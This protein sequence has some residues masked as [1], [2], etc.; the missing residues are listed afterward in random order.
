VKNRCIYFNQEGYNQG[1]ANPPKAGRL[2]IFLGYAPTVGKTYAMLD[3]ALRMR[4]DGMPVVVACL[5]PQGDG[6]YQDQLKALGYEDPGSVPKNLDLDVLLSH[7]K[8]LV[9]VDELAAKNPP[10]SRHPYRYQDVEELLAAGRDVYTTLNIQELESLRDVILE[11]DNRMVHETVPDRIFRAASVIELIDLPPEEILQRLERKMASGEIDA[12]EAAPYLSIE[13]LT[14]LRQIALRRTAGT[15]EE[16]YRGKEKEKPDGGVLVC[17]SSHPLSERL[18]RVGKRRADEQHVPWHVLYIETPERARPLVAYRE[19]LERSLTLAEQLGARVHRQ[20]SLDLSR[21]V[22]A[23]V[24]QN[25]IHSVVVGAPRHSGRVVFGKTQVERLVSM[26]DSAEILIVKEDRKLSSMDQPL[27]SGKREPWLDYAKA[28]GI[29]ALVTGISYPL[30]L[31]I[32]PVN[33]VMLYLVAVMACAFY[34]GRGPAI[35]AS[36]TSVLAFDYFMV[37]PR[38]SLTIADTQYLL[39]FLGLFIAGLVISSLV[40]KI[41]GQVDASHQREELISALYNLSQELTEAYDRDSV[42]KTILR[43]IR[44]TFVRECSLWLV[45]DGALISYPE[46]TPD[47]DGQ[48]TQPVGWVLENRRPAGKGTDT[49]PELS[50]SY[51]PMVTG[52]QVVGIIEVQEVASS[53]LMNLEKRDLLEAYSGIAALAIERTRLLEEQKKA[54]LV[55]ETERLQNALL[56][57]ISHDLRTP[58]ATISGVLTS[59]RESEQAGSDTIPLPDQ[60]RLELL[61]SGWEETQRLNRIVGNL[62]DIARLESGAL[63]LNLQSG[64]LE[65]VLGAVLA[66]MQ[67]RLEGFDLQIEFASNLPALLF[68]PGLIEQV[69]ANILDNAVK[70]SGREKTIRISVTIMDEGVL[71]Y[72]RDHGAGLPKKELSKIFEKFYRS[73]NVAGISGSGLGLSICKGII[74]AHGG[75]IWAEASLPHGLTIQFTLPVR[76]EQAHDSG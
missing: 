76:K 47:T 44:N 64:D 40:G 34:L 12:V 51:Y 20:T 54:Q 71:V 48:D 75:R 69:F 29:V 68:D 42:I 39:T 72:I 59:L 13:R 35:L 15:I 33:L 52:S 61:E 45:E 37:T 57:S 21:A 73:D 9:L 31:M 8:E 10:G 19:R 36:I 16:Q 30:H 22:A 24:R 74:Q 4:G 41:R 60:T 6:D 5:S 7:P 50:S 1:M 14:R 11:I 49:Y 62:L 23:F 67:P 27:F 70:F 17:I 38:F 2:K 3:A 63:R 46:T 65:G 53:V 26:V 25:N 58:L 32:E 66:H 28:L 55:L 56:N 18:V 43:Q